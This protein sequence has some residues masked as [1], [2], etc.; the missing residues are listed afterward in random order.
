[1]TQ[2]SGMPSGYRTIEP[3]LVAM[4]S[5][6]GR[7][8]SSMLSAQSLA[9]L[10]PHTHL[11]PSPLGRRLLR[12]RAGRRECE[13][14]DG[15][16]EDTLTFPGWAASDTGVPCLGIA[17]CFLKAGV[18]L[19]T[20]TSLL[21]CHWVCLVLSIILGERLHGLGNINSKCPGT[22]PRGRGAAIPEVSGFSPITSGYAVVPLH[23]LYDMTL[24]TGLNPLV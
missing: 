12:L 10:H 18:G 15:P 20:R 23:S 2:A 4:A 21:R 7:Q 6:W 9:A 13:G 3:L 24:L 14:V 17:S 16:E 11:F 1:M 19:P 5:G 22:Q 8:G